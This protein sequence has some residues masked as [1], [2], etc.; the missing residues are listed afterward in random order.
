MPKAKATSKKNGSTKS[1]GSARR[2]YEAEAQGLLSLRLIAAPNPKDDLT[3]DELVAICKDPRRS[4]ELIQHLI[5]FV[6]SM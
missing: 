1:A 4:P 6:K 2:T 5:E 3:D